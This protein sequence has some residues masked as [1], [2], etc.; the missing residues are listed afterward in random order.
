MRASNRIIRQHL[1]L[2]PATGEDETGRKMNREIVRNK[3]KWKARRMETGEG[4]KLRVL[5]ELTW[6]QHRKMDFIESE[7]R[8][9]KSAI[10]VQFVDEKDKTSEARE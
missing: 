9:I 7:L 10:N 3:C 8:K 6:H 2:T 5:F 4:V 1:D